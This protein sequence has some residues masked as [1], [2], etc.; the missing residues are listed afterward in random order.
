MHRSTTQ[1]SAAVK[2]TN[3][4]HQE[5]DLADGGRCFVAGVSRPRALILGVS[6]LLLARAAGLPPDGTAKVTTPSCKLSQA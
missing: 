1:T 2:M 6:L 5:S 4:C 3:K